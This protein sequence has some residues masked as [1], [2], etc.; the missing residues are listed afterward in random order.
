MLEVRFLYKLFSTCMEGSF[1]LFIVRFYLF[2]LD[3][4]VDGSNDH[5]NSESGYTNCNPNC[6]NSDV[7][8]AVCL[9]TSSDLWK[10][11]GMEAWYM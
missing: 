11:K 7:R 9:L 8:A 6:N 2:S 1:L 10:K 3:A 5:H 4:A